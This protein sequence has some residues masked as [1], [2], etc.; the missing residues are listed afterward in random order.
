MKDISPR[1][2]QILY[3]LSLEQIQ[4]SEPVASTQIKEKYKL[5]FSSATIRNELFRLCQME[6]LLQPHT[7]AGRVLSDFGWEILIDQ[8][9]TNVFEIK[10]FVST[11][12]FEILVKK[13]CNKTEAFT[14]IYDFSEDKIYHTGLEYLIND[15]TIS[16]IKELSSVAK[17]F[18]SLRDNIKNI[19]HKIEYS[20]IN[21]FIGKKN[22]LFKVD[23]LTLICTKIKHENIVIAIVTPK[24]TDY[25]K[26]FKIFKALINSS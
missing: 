13:I 24:V 20:Q 14:F 17:D 6:Y 25:E 15:K 7:S 1:Q 12:D 16:D 22:P 8:F 11:D 4:N 10:S 9:L 5:N 2:K 21:V 19:K 23:Y 26:H 3:Y 18:D